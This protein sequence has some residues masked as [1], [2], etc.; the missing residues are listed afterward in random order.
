MFVVRWFYWS[1]QTIRVVS[2]I[3]RE[4]NNRE[5]VTQS[6]NT[7]VTVTDK[8][9]LDNTDSITRLFVFVISRG[10]TLIWI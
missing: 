10:G 8:N 1:A 4:Q 2:Q 6:E 5:D 9:W 7:D 3:Y